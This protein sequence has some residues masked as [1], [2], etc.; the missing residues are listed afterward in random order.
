MDFNSTMVYPV[1]SQAK[2]DKMKDTLFPTI[3]GSAGTGA[4]IV[5]VN[6]WLSFACAILTII[7]LSIS[8]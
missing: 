6:P 4:T 3:L 8:I 5:I 1:G 2:G 7:Y